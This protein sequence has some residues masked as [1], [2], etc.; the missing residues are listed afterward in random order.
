MYKII[1]SK[2]IYK[3]LETLPRNDLIKIKLKI[4]GLAENPRP[5]G[6]EK[7][8]GTDNTYRIRGGNYRIIYEIYDK[9]I[10][11]EIINVDDRKQVYR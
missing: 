8:K 10:L 9:K 2:K 3:K 1:I 7:L 5:Q 4:D 6:N 11:V